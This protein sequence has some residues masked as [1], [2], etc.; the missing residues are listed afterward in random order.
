[1]LVVVVF[2]TDGVAL[3]EIGVVTIWSVVGKFRALVAAV[4]IVRNE[5]V[6]LA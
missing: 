2:R 1:M 6:I 5:S 4:F 3:A